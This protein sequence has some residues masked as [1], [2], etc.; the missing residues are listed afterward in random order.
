M[1]DMNFTDMAPLS[2]A[3]LTADG[4]LVA[5]V[6]C[7]RTG[8]QQ[9]RASDLGM[10]GNDVVTVFRPEATVF[11]KDS[12]ATFAGKPVTMGH[13]EGAVSADNWRALA[14]GDIGTEI[15]RDGEYV[16]VPLK[17]MDAAAIKAVMDGTREI[18]MGYSVGIEMQDGVAPDG[19][20]Y[21][22]IQTGH[23][24][25][26][27]LAIVSAA[28]GGANLRIG[29][30]AEPW[31]ASPLSPDRKDIGMTDT[32]MKTVVLGDKAAVTVPVTDALTIE[33]FKDAAT[34]ASAKLVAD[35]ATALATKDAALATKDAEITALKAKVLDGGALDKLVSDRADLI[36]K[37]KAITAGI[38]TDGKSAAEIKRATVIA[39]AGAAMSDKSEAYL[40]AMFDIL[41]TDAAKNSDPAAKALADGTA[42]VLT[43][44][45][46]LYAQRALRLSDAWKP[47]PK[48]EAV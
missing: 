38:V 27:H 18:S 39:K 23:L 31:G 8:C 1:T 48:K 34:A 32:P 5:N 41:A 33:A 42:P 3:R 17:L 40:D 7:A 30:S 16:T 19:T 20:P 12:L 25:V 13:P 11:A 28:R 22:A 43:D 6:R 45:D 21:Q 26:N 37:A 24:R 9:Y 10:T 47:Q 4:Y 35:H 36:G 14:V 15:A 29:D 2:G 46:T 44:A